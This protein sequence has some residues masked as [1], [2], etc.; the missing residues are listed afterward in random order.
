MTL[1]YMKYTIRY[2]TL[3]THGLPKEHRSDQIRADV[4]VEYDM[5]SLWV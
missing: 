1:H 4:M 5:L 3:T 2:S